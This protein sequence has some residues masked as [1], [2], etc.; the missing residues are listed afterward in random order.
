MDRYFGRRHRRRRSS[1]GCSFSLVPSELLSKFLAAKANE[2]ET[3]SSLLFAGTRYS[4]RPISTQP[5]ARGAASRRG[6]ALLYVG[7][8]WSSIRGSAGSPTLFNLRLRDRRRP[9]RPSSVVVVNYAVDPCA[10]MNHRCTI[11]GSPLSK[12]QRIRKG[13]ITSSRNNESSD[14]SSISLLS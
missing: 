8:A 7:Q 5:E 13:Q 6:Q 1:A 2:R 11:S 4:R 10:P 14:V 3:R 9:F 12:V